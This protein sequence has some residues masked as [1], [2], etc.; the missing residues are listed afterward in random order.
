VTVSVELRGVYNIS[1][2]T[3]NPSFEIHL[4]AINDCRASKERSAAPPVSD[5]V[6]PVVDIEGMF[7]YI[8][9]HLTLLSISVPPD[10]PNSGRP[11]WKPFCHQ[12]ALATQIV[13]RLDD[14]A[15]PDSDPLKSSRLLAQDLL[16][17]PL[18]K[19]WLTLRRLFKPP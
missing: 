8:P 16:F 14:G 13:A 7:Y 17:A 10:C 2:N 9:Y 5:E 15:L 3:S 11:H 4:D 12:R 18:P 6:Q 19:T 1:Y